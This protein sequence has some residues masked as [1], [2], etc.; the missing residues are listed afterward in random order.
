MSEL[1][2]RRKPHFRRVLRGGARQ[3]LYVVFDEQKSQDQKSTNVRDSGEG[4][5]LWRVIGV[6]GNGRCW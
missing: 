2:K 6:A 1:P 5:L 3:G 4:G